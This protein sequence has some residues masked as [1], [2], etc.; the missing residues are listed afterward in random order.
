MVIRLSDSIITIIILNFGNYP[1]L[2]FGCEVESR[3]EAFI[4]KSFIQAG[5][6]IDI[7]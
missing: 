2:V 4:S 6:Y 3:S 1:Y 7:E 5:E